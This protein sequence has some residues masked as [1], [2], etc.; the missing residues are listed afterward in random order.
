MWLDLDRLTGKVPTDDGAIWLKVKRISW[1][2]KG[3]VKKDHRP[4]HEHHRS[5]EP[6]LHGEVKPTSAHHSPT[7]PHHGGHKPAQ[8]PSFDFQDMNSGF[9][10][11][12]HH[13][14]SPALQPLPKKQTDA[15]IDLDIDLS[16]MGTPSTKK[17]HSKNSGNLMEDLLL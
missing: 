13:D 14:K 17:E 16:G 3:S 9:G 8:K 2:R 6:Q 1:E 15:M 4:P 7:H 11:H 5:A 12:H 10:V